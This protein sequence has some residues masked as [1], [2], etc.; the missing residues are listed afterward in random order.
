MCDTEYQNITISSILRS[1]LTNHELAE[2]L[3]ALTLD[4][5]ITREDGYAIAL[6]LMQL[7]R[8]VSDSRDTGTP[9]SSR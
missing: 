2:L 6:E 5:P 4:E 8:A 7:R 1:R 3:L 9:G